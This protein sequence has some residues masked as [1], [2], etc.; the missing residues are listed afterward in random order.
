MIHNS[1]RME[2]SMLRIILSG[3]GGRMGQV[4][5]SMVEKMDNA[6]IVAGIDVIDVDSP[7]PVFKTLGECDVEG[8][9]VIDFTSPKNSEALVAY[10][11]EKHLPV[12]LATT[13]QEPSQLALIE[14]AAEHIALFRSGNMSLGI[15][16]VQ[17]L[18]QSTTKVLGDRYDIEIIEKHHNQKKD[19]PSGTALMLADSV[20]E[21]RLKKLAYINGRSG[22]DALRSPSELGIHA[23]RGGTI[24][25]QHQVLFSGDDE[26]ISIEHH[27]YSRQ[28]FA[29]GAIRAASYVVRQKPG[30][31]S[32][33]DMIFEE[34]AITTLYVNEKQIL[35]S[36][37]SLPHDM[38]AVSE[39][40]SALAEG[41]ILV[42]MIS[43]TGSSNG[44]IYIAFTIE[45]RSREKA[46]KILQG[47]IEG[48]ESVKVRIVEDVT[49]LTVEGPGM[50]F[51]SGVASRLFSIM[52]HSSIDV[53]AVSTSEIKISFVT[54]SQ[55]VEKATQLIKEEFR[56]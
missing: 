13:G 22:A 31:Y 9:V 19:A 42:D 28:V 17:Q 43:H 34:S 51:Q 21:V 36:V 56:I 54:H 47:Y 50:E 24:V 41:D 49:K 3:C 39:L 32:M 18:L 11:V 12:V 53:L 2:D 26:L 15:N 35:V 40:Y 30:L 4:I 23:I 37:D 29:T 45:E 38:N 52:A 27:A 48:Y 10:A 25:G 5:T 7:Y 14:Q 1:T 44:H 20:N 46:Q 6:S 8:D 55:D 33:Q 16:L